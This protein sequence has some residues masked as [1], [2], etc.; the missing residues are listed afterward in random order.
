[1]YELFTLQM[2][3]NHICY[4]DLCNFMRVSSC[5]NLA[6]RGWW[7]H[8]TVYCMC[9]SKQGEYQMLTLLANSS[10]LFTLLEVIGWLVGYQL[11]EKCLSGPEMSTSQLQ[12]HADYPKEV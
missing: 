10:I 3:V 1:M 2:R 7:L 12:S 11:S 9:S 6:R 8:T 4:W 5:Y